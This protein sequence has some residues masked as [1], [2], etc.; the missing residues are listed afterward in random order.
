MLL[1]EV[2]EMCLRVPVLW[3]AAAGSER[4]RKGVVLLELEAE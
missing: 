3:L 2:W 1:R 4:E